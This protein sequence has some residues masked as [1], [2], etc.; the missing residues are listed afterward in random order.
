[1]QLKKKVFT[2][3]LGFGFCS[4]V[5]AQFNPEKPNLRQSNFF[6]FEQALKEHE[7]M[8]NAYVDAVSWKKK[9]MQIRQGILDGAELSH[10]KGGETVNASIHS[11]KIMKGYSVE[12]VFFESVAGIYVSGNLYKPLKMKGKAAGILAPH[13]HGDNLRLGEATQ[14]RCATMAKMGAIVFAYDMIG[15]GDMQ[16]C[17]HKIEKALKLQLIN[18]IRS[19]DFLSQMSNIDKDRIAITG[20]SGGGTQTFL[21]AAIDDRIKV[22]VP[23]VM[24]SGYFYGGCNCESGM[25]IHVR[26]THSTTNAEIAACVAPKPLLLVSDGAD[27]TKNNPELELPFIKRIYGFFKAEKYIENTHLPLEQHDYGFSKRKAAYAFLGKH[28]KLE[29]SKADETGNELLSKEKL[30][31]FTDIYPLP[32]NALI[33]DEAIM[34][35]LDTIK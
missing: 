35:K 32:K 17:E 16:Q 6:T 19:L 27:W 33:G 30:S 34:S 25:P 10:F 24:V 21:L 20:E 14:Q 8:G 28:L 29:I 1:M 22:S 9:A 12:N 13:G 3:F 5:F 31:V 18:S 7:N 4:Q 26:P 2:V 11:K 23:V 15:H